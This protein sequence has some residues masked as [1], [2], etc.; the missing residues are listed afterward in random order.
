MIGVQLTDADRAFSCV[1]PHYTWNATVI[2]DIL[3]AESDGISDVIVLS[4]VECMIF[5]GQRSRGHGFT[6]AEAM[7]F[8]REIHDP[9]TLRIGCHTKMRCVPQML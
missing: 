4:P 9:H 7:N 5:T 8:A 2:K 3:G 1:L 6:Q